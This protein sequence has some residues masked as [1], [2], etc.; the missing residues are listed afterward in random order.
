MRNRARWIKWGRL[1]LLLLLLG[2]IAL[3]A[4]ELALRPLVRDY[5]VNR[6]RLFADEVM[7]RAVNRVLAGEEDLSGLMTVTR[8]ETGA[9][10]SAQADAAAVNR[11]CAAVVLEL[12]ELLQQTPYDQFTF[13]LGSVTGSPLLLERGP[14]VTVRLRPNGAVSAHM[15]STFSAAGIN[16]TL[17]RLELTLTFRVSVLAP[18]ISEPIEVTGNFLIA[19]TVI[20]G[21]VPDVYAI[22][23]YQ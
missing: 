11:I 3:V 22:R 6:S 23:G 8:D 2:L 13:P 21:R 1:G 20:V 17:H 19:E 12:G 15:N 9:L 5:A 10:L 14:G 4:L 16:Q 7:A 18:G